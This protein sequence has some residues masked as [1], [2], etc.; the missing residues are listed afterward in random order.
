MET[1]INDVIHNISNDY[2]R[3]D[4]TIFNEILKSQS[5]AIISKISKIN[6]VKIAED[7]LN[8]NRAL[9]QA[10]LLLKYSY[11]HRKKVL[12]I[13][14]G[15]GVAH[16]VWT[17]KYKIDGYCLEPGGAGFE[18]SYHLSRYLIKKNGL[19]DRR[20]IKATG[21]HIPFDSNKFDIIYSS[22][23][24]EHTQNPVLG[25]FEAARVLK[26]GGII[27]FIYPNYYSYFDGHYAVFHPPIFW[28]G[29]FPWYVQRIWGRDASFSRG[30]RTELNIKWTRNVIEDLQ[31]IYQLEVLTLGEDIFMDR[32][33]N[34]N[35]QNWAGLDKVKKLAIFIK[36]LR[37]NSLAA[38]IVLSLGGWT[39]IILTLRK[40]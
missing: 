20:I 33:K 34:T 30:L 21:E 17:K 5:I 28:K 27:Q 8:A 14:S 29:F 35:F 6:S 18:S 26:T 23:V 25:L 32:M 9:E 15:L 7:S 24:L 22:N 1:I 16:I 13:G 2:C 19:D 37:I 10:A 11:L 4:S 40:K 36:A 39:P 3:I 12:E 31:K 38:K